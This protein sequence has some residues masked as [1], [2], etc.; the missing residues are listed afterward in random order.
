MMNFQWTTA[1]V[2][3]WTTRILSVYFILDVVEKLSIFKAYKKSGFFGQTVLQESGFYLSRSGLMRRLLNVIYTFRGWLLLM[4]T[5]GIC[6]MAIFLW[7]AHHLLAASCLFLLI[8][9]SSLLNLRCRPFAAE[10]ENRFALMILAALFFQRILPTVAVT[11]VCFWFIALQSCL[12]YTTA[13]ISKLFVREWRN[14]NGLSMMLESRQ[15]IDS[16]TLVVFFSTKK[17]FLKL[18]TWTVIVMD[19]LFPLVLVVGDPYFIV[20]IIWGF[21]FHLF[22]AVCLRIGK[23]FWVWTATYP[24][25][26]YV[27]TNPGI[28]K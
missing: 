4:V 21:F 25:I 6:G 12:S 11:H 5:R 9:V 1:E 3:I 26:M 14:G 18:M 23:F 24:V 27:A 13:G 15:V 10:T 8:L 20:F 7:P 16:D 2:I 22:I 17:K 19:A 28:F